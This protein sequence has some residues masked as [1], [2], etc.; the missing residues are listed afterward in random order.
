MHVAGGHHRLVQLFAQADNGLV[1][2]PE[3][4][5]ILCHSLQD[6]EAVVFNGLY[7]QIV[8]KGGNLQQLPLRLA[9][10]HGPEQLPGLTG[11]AHQQAVP[12]LDKLTFGDAGTLVK[13]VEVSHG[14]EAVQVF[15]PRQIAHQQYLVIAGQLFGVSA[16]QS[17]VDFCGRGNIPLLHS[18]DHLQKDF[19][20]NLRVIACPVVLEGRQL[21]KMGYLVQLMAFQV[22]E[23]AAAEL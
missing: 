10:R 23:K 13:V 12:V 14:N 17:A 18:L 4:F 7:L 11:R 1:E 9:L 5:L 6:H 2:L 22:R 3:L 21:E 15:Q 8:V 16:G 20:Q 19:S